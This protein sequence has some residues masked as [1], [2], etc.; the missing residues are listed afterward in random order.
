[1]VS[2]G[3]SSPSGLHGAEESKDLWEL[4]FFLPQSTM[5]MLLYQGRFWRTVYLS[6]L[7]CGKLLFLLGMTDKLSGEAK[8]DFGG[9]QT[10][11]PRSPQ[12]SAVWL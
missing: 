2:D 3:H 4:L 11:V 5:G 8:Y 12:G 9:T 1:M 6:E 7:A 10:M